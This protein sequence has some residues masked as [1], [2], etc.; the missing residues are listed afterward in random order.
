MSMANTT[1]VDGRSGVIEATAKLVIKNFVDVM[2][3][4]KPGMCIESDQF[5]L[6]D[7]PLS[8]MVYPNGDSH[9][10]KGHVGLYLHNNGDDV[11]RA[12]GQLITDLNT[13]NFEYTEF[14]EA[15]ACWGIGK[16]LTHA[17]CADAYKNKD[18]VVEAKLEI[19][20]EVTKIA[21][22]QSAA[23]PKKFNVLEKVYNK[24]AKT[25]FILIFEGEE[26]PCH[27][28]ILAAASPVLDAMVENKHR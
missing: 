7:T 27:K 26:V 20:G 1:V 22:S 18:F 10:F 21:G 2:A 4:F 24:M 3:G 6:G 25:D 16:F 19:P 14:V 13:M 8:I 15:K 12:K 17:Q 23:A 5:M 11:I 28:I 9:Y